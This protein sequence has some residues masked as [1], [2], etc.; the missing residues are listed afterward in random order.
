MTEQKK[1]TTD[2][3]Y[4]QQQW[5]DNLSFSRKAMDESK[6]KTGKIENT[7]VPK[8]RMSRTS[9][10]AG[11]LDAYVDEMNKEINRM[12]DAVG[13]RMEQVGKGITHSVR[14]IVKPVGNSVNEVAGTAAD[15]IKAMGTGIGK[16]MLTEFTSVIR[17]LGDKVATPNS[18]RRS[19]P[20]LF[21]DEA[22]TDIPAAELS[23]ATH[24][25]TFACHFGT[26]LENKIFFATIHNRP[27]LTERDVE[28]YR[29]GD[30]QQA[31]EW[32]N[33]GLEE[34]RNCAPYGQKLPTAKKGPY[35]NVPM[36]DVLMQIS[37]EDLEAFLHFVLNRP[38]PFQQKALKLSEAFAT[39]VH[40]GAPET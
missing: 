20:S 22:E 6:K 25:R 29:P 15:S 7:P 31:Y 10:A 8:A 32:M 36:Y 5:S 27:F 38:L 18:V 35:L 39:W 26:L 11:Q 40:K 4:R 9:R 13:E 24:V 37:F 28:V 19:E 14:R 1:P 2:E 34:I 16:A 12:S 21:V 33:R 17:N 23:P 3:L 30:A